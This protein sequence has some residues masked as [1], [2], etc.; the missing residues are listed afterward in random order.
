MQ[1]YALFGQKAEQ[2]TV[3]QIYCQE[4]PLSDLKNDREYS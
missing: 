4:I 3:R 2:A 1:N